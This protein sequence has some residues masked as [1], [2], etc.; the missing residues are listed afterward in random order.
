MIKPFIV[1]S[2]LEIVIPQEAMEWYIQSMER[3]TIKN[4]IY[5]QTVPKNAALV[6]Y[7]IN[8]S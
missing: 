3:K 6:E 7:S 8:F 4:Y 2:L 5:K 1:D